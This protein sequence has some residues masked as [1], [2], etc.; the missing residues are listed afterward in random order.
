VNI[1]P[2]NQV[3]GCPGWAYGLALLDI[4]GS[5]YG[6]RTVEVYRP[7]GTVPPFTVTSMDGWAG[8]HRQAIETIEAVA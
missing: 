6:K 7:D 1:A 8:I 3:P 4:D 2:A 5:L